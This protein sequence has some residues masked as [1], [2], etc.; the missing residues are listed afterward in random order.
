MKRTDFST[1]FTL[2]GRSIQDADATP[3]YSYERPSNILWNAAM[4]G[5]REAGFTE[6]QG[7]EYLA[8][9]M[10]RYALDGELGDAIE[11]LGYEFGK[12]ATK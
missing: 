6:K 2:Y 8:S 9:K 10:P 5:L 11:K 12:R 3:I 7:R 1:A 4:R